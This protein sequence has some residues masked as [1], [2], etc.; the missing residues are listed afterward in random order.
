[1][2]IFSFLWGKIQKPFLLS[3]NILLSSIS[4]SERINEKFTPLFYHY[5]LFRVEMNIMEIIVHEKYEGEVKSWDFDFALL[6]T[7][8]VIQF[9]N[10]IRP[11][12]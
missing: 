11:V 4:G 1:M 9:T 5:L 3:K 12:S 8:E 7:E 10:Y 2:F 6:R